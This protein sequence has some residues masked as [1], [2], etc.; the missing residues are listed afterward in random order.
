MDHSWQQNFKT[1]DSNDIMKRNLPRCPVQVPESTC[2]SPPGLSQHAAPI[3]L[4]TP[5]WLSLLFS[6]AWLS[7]APTHALPRTQFLSDLICAQT[8]PEGYILDGTTT[9][10]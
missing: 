4:W 3:L 10:V 7:P 8:C 5:C 2:A 6:S 9:N 1:V